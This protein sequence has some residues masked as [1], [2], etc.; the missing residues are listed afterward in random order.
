[1]KN[2]K[3]QLA[4]AWKHREAILGLT[5]LITLLICALALIEVIIDKTL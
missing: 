3:Q 5:I 2:I 4:Y 1:M